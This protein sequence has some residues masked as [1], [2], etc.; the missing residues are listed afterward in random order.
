MKMPTY[1]VG[2]LPVPSRKLRLAS[3]FLWLGC[4]LCYAQQEVPKQQADRLFYAQ[5][6]P[7]AASSY[8]ELL[9]D[10][11]LAGDARKDA[12]Y[13]LAYA[14]KELGE[15]AKAESS[16]RELLE[17]G[18]PAG[19]YQNA[20]LYYAQ[21][22]G[23]NGKLTEAQEMY[24]RYE[25]VKATLGTG[26]TNYRPGAVGKGD[27]KVTYR[28]ERLGIDTDNAEFSPA[29]FREGLV[30]VAGKGSSG[31]STS[32]D[33][34]YLDL[35][36]V[37]NRN[38]LT[39]TGVI[40]ADGKLVVVDDGRTNVD[41]SNTYANRRLGRDNYTRATA[42]DSRTAASYAP[43]S[44]SSGLGLNKN[45]RKTAATVAPEEFSKDLNTKYHEGP[46]TFSAD[47]SQ[48]IF[49]R[50]NYNEGKSRKSTDNVT[51]LKLYSADLSDGGWANVQ[52]LPFNSDEYSSG[53]PALSRDG[54][55][56]Y[57]VS[58]RPGGRGG[59]DV[60]VARSDGGTWSQP[61]N[62]GPQINTR[63][64]EMFPFVDENGILYFASNGHPG[65]L[66]G[67]D[68]YYTSLN[69]GENSQ[70]SHLEAP[71]NSKADDFGL[72]TDGSRSTGYFSSNRLN[73]D[74]DIFRFYRESSLYGCRNLSL[75]VFDEAS[76]AALDNVTVTI[77]ARGEGRDE[78]TLTTDAEGMIDICLEAEND[79]IFELA[80]DG[81][82][83]GT[84]GFSTKGLTDD[85]STRLGSSLIK[86]NIIEADRTPG[87]VTSGADDSGDW[88][89]DDA[90]S[91]P[92]LRGTVTGEADNK[93][94]EGVK[95]ILKNECDG[96]VK[97]T[98]TGPS[99]R[100]RFEITEGCDYTLV[101][102][103][104]SY[105]T[106]TNAI[107]KTPVASKPKLVSANIVMIKAGD[108]VTLD[109]IHYDSGKW[110]VRP[111]AA[112]ELDRLVA[113]M[114]KYPSLQIEI[115]SHT[116]SQGEA[117]FNQYLSE[118][119]AKAA[120]NYLASKGIS[121]NRLSA[122]GYGES[123]LLNKCKDGVL[124]TEEEHER[125]RRTE[126]KVLSIN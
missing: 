100:F 52:E 10:R 22:L 105:G 77:R 11:S 54:R 92:T 90:I 7:G 125:N 104:T 107:R 123:Q 25:N 78:K 118:R 35:F 62:L 72:I 15:S 58:D 71:I 68:I 17:L 27:S 37:P 61:L 6:Y 117:Q 120:L 57:F 16:F 113:T 34:G 89:N 28:V 36:Y 80:K 115:G 67:L 56:L 114:R 108:L 24:A 18:E 13:N 41:G 112:K 103:K 55:S 49:T 30:Y 65:S 96:K 69:G 97:Q 121:R 33:K 75:K 91:A 93:P 50:N 66:G 32:P 79:F 116:D 110:E 74:D 122:K 40:G 94:I 81:Y 76:Y 111:D 98:V 87:R 95:I 82:L 31:A 1:P 42:N 4:T 51:K 126:L 5:N 12:L 45:E 106:N 101:A 63:G 86:Y 8:A 64:D 19:K 102:T 23:R 99:G 119:R 124:C 44:F 59:T 14:Y 38:D 53:H 60:Y 47:G 46:L 39:A 20:Y 3:L 88:E 2:Y 73:G 109:N 70:I 26:P 48:V 21:A 85:K 84:L 43:M 83:T 9:K 29:Y